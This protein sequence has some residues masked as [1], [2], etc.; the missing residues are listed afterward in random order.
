MNVRD[1]SLPR[2]STPTWKHF[3]GLFYCTH[4]N[5]HNLKE[6]R[7]KWELLKYQPAEGG[8][9]NERTRG[10]FN[11]A[12]ARARFLVSA[13]VPGLNR[14]QNRKFAEVDIKGSYLKVQLLMHTQ[15]GVI[16]RVTRLGNVFNN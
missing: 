7:A 8:A 11:P 4:K 14:I 16:F 5:N 12:R 9:E 15:N 1:C 3:Q 6:V 13:R 10:D 2:R